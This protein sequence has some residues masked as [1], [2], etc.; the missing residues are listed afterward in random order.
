MKWIWLMSSIICEVAGTTALK[1]VSQGGRY[2]T[3]W[4]VS[5]F[6]FYIACF[7]L[8]G[9]TFRYFDLGL[10][11]AIWSGIGITLMA[12][13]GLLFF[14]DSMNMMKFFSIVLIIMG[15]AGLNLSGVSH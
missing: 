12:I 15:I 9:I 10:V 2:T 11:Y 1:L 3:F 13:I 7:G 4:I 14:G 6:V 8:M 5:V